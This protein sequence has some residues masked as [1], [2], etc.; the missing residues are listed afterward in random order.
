MKKRV[1]AVFM[2]AV[3]VLGLASCGSS[4]AK[5]T[6]GKDKKASEESK[7]DDADETEVQVFIAASLNT[8]MTEIAEK[9]NKDNPDVKITFN[10]DS[11]G[12][13]LTQIEEGY[14]CDIFFSAAQK[15]MDQLEQ[16]GLVREGTRANV[17]NNQVVLVTRKDSGTK[18]SGLEDLKD[19]QSIALAGGSV[20]VGKY[21][22]QALVNLGILEKTDEPDAVTTEQVSEALG[23]VEISEQDNVSKVL[24]A[25]V[26]G[27][28]EVGTT[29]YSDTYGYED[30]LDILETVGYDLTGNVIYPICLV[31]NQ[32]AD[33]AQS[34]AAKDFYDY[35]LSE[36]ASEIFYNYYF[37]TN[38][39]R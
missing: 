35:V 9:Y 39:Q 19:A 7:K 24:A 3:M 22:R 32:E 13:L 17:V 28:C 36:D 26:E 16:D 2:A 8:V 11:S 29:Y 6:D 23:G 33:D 25:V 1:V 30:D 4:E 20:P 14:E 38:V 5:K 34:R 21:T 37:D 10:A 12:T 31:D 15:Q 18:A 27:S